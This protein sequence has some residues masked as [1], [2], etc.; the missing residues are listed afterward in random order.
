MHLAVCV[1]PPSKLELYKAIEIEVAKNKE[2]VPIGYDEWSLP[3][4]HYL[5]QYLFK[6]SPHHKYF[7]KDYVYKWKKIV[8]SITIK[9]P[10]GFLQG[11]PMLNAGGKKNKFTLVSK[12]KWTEFKLQYLKGKSDA[13]IDQLRR[14]KYDLQE[15]D[16]EKEE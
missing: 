15:I 11:L 12:R 7:L 8:D 10:E 14:K 4:K 3:D 9:L 5:I 16:D 2:A 13:V 6:Q 1:N